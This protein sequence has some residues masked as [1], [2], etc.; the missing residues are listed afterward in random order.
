MHDDKWDAGGFFPERAFG[1]VLLF[2]EVKTVVAPKHDDGVVFVRA[3]AESFEGFAD[4]HVHKADACAIGVNEAAPL[5][6]LFHFIRGGGDLDH[7]LRVGRDASFGAF[8][9]VI[10]AGSYM[11]CHFGGTCGRKITQRVRPLPPRLLPPR[12][13]S[14][15]PSRS[16]P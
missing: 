16:S 1:K 15:S 5:A 9:I 7:V 4:A 11:A 14:P 10:F 6:G 12:S 13:I 8:G 3:G 2:A